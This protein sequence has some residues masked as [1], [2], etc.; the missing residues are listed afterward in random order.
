MAAAVSVGEREVCRWRVG[1]GWRAGGEWREQLMT[2]V[3]ME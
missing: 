2:A 3:Q 1:G